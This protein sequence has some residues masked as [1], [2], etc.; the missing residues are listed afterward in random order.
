LVIQKGVAK[1]VI[2]CRDPFEKVNGLG[3]EKLKAAGIKVIEG[4][5]EKEAGE[6]NK[7]FFTFHQKKRPYIFLK[8]A[9]TQDG[10]IA[11][12]G[13]ERLAISNTYSNT[14]THKMRAE[15]AAVLVGT[16]TALHDNPALTTRNWVGKHPL[17]IVIDKHLKLPGTLNLFS[18]NHPTVV[19]NYLKEQ[20]EGQIYFLKIADKEDLLAQLMKYLYEHKI[21]SLIVEGGSILLSAF[22]AQ[23]VWDEAVVITN[24]KLNIQQGLNAP[25]LPMKKLITAMALSSDTIQRFR[26]R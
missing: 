3:I 4:V 18:D 10:F 26:N 22:I 14:F 21:Q 5:L 24:K 25:E 6:L 17:R 8:W 19:V 16:N 1:V 11:R 13:Y 23:N 20:Q 2:A 12:A 15:E 9:Q 7:R